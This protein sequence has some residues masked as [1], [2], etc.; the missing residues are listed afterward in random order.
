[1]NRRGLIALLGGSALA[2]PLIA[3]AQQKRAPVV[4]VLGGWAIDQVAPNLAALRQALAENGYV[5]GQNVTIEY[6]GADGHYDRFPALAADLV[7]R[8]VDV[9]VSTA[10][11]L[12]ARAVKN[13]TSTIPIVFFTGG[14]PVAD[15]LVASFARPGGNLTGLSI[16]VSE[17]GPKRL[18]LLCELVPQAKMIALLV[19]PAQ[20]GALI[21]SEME[22][23]A[24][25]KGVQLPILKA[26]TE[27]EFDAAFASL[28]ALHAD[29][30]IVGGDSFFNSRHEQIAS[31][32]ARYA[33]P[34]VFPIH[35]YAASGGLISYGSNFAV[36]WRQLGIYAGK[37]LDGAKPADLPVQRPTTFELVINL[38][39][40]KALG[41]TVPQSILIRAD[42]V[43]E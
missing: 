32:A 7:A 39:T 5:D 1:M 34:A 13:A 16:M 15:G 33:V 35:E 27:S 20:P 25:A 3:R 31:L 42:E 21:S 26:G 43:I 6:R 22:A 12:S 11:T 40:A 29:G 19:N 41:I 9:I 17:L 14:D 2:W 37:I 10:G 36:G 8:K 28:A 30:L 23:A 38:K 4:A 24:R 18:D